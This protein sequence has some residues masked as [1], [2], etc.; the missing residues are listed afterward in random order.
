[1]AALALLLLLAAALT[2]AQ[3]PIT[4]PSECSAASSCTLTGTDTYSCT[5]ATPNSSHGWQPPVN[6]KN[7]QVEAT[8]GNGGATTN[9][10]GGAGATIQATYTGAQPPAIFVFYVGQ[11]GTSSISSMPAALTLAVLC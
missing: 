10:L 9:A 6:A 8:G 3:Q 2:A 7:I 11:T 5:Y 1:M 4:C